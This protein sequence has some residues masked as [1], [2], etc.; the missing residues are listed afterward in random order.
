[1]FDPEFGTI[2]NELAASKDIIHGNH[3]V[4]YK[5]FHLDHFRD[6]L[7][8][9]Y[10]EDMPKEILDVLYHDAYKLVFESEND[11]QPKF[12]KD[13][14]VEAY[15]KN[16]TFDKEC[17]Y[18]D[19]TKVIATFDNENATNLNYY[20]GDIVRRYRLYGKSII[21]TLPL[22]DKVYTKVARV[23]D[24][25]ILEYAVFEDIG[26]TRYFIMRTDRFNIRDVI[27]AYTDMEGSEEIKLL[28]PELYERSPYSFPI[29]TRK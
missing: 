15:V 17:T 14:F 11:I 7:K 9:F 18:G 1:M 8:Y 4:E 26:D 21:V 27:T 16:D 13:G 3:S 19:M 22:N 6:I 25:G 12:E 28:F 29:R 23:N 24:D 10:G 2:V 20:K 5:N